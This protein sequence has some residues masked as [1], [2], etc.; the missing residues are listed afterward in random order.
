[1]LFKDYYQKVPQKIQEITDSFETSDT[2]AQIAI[3]HSVDNEGLAN[4]ELGRLTGQVLVGMLPPKNFVPALVEKLNIPKEKAQEIAKEINQKIFSQVKDLLIEIHG[5]KK[6]QK[7]A[8]TESFGETKQKKEEPAEIKVPKKL[9]IPMPKKDHGE[10]KS[11]IPKL[12]H[13]LKKDLSDEKPKNPPLPPTKG[14]GEKPLAPP[15]APQVPQKDNGVKLPSP[16]QTSKS[17]YKTKKIPVPSAPQ[18]H[19]IASKVPLPKK[20]ESSLETTLKK[21]TNPFEEKLRQ[22]FTIPTVPPK[23]LSVPSE[24]V[25]KKS[26]LEDKN[27]PVGEEEGREITEKKEAIKNNPYLETIE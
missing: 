13:E 26:G 20:Q 24:Q 17:P 10:I 18:K 1:M 19:I 15:L 25:P 3:D 7:P 23:D 21:S 2:L 27:S 9:K 8:I 11:E 5:L 6:T 22:T 16:I 4:R 12:K 14:G